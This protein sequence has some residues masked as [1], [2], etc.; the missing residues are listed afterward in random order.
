MLKHTIA[1]KFDYTIQLTS[2]SEPSRFRLSNSLS[3]TT[4]ADDDNSG[5][6]QFCNY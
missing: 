3:L 4:F 1:T 6:K 2:L 5:L